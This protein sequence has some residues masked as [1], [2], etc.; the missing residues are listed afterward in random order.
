MAIANIAAV[1]A[2]SGGLV[3]APTGIGHIS[4]NMDIMAR[5]S[6]HDIAQEVWALALSGFTTDDSAGKRLKDAERAAK[7]AVV[8]SA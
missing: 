8:L 6:P 5:P 3:A 4:A 7:T 2:G 1:L